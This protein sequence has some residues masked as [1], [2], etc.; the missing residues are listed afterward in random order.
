MLPENNEFDAVAVDES[1][2][3]AWPRVAAVAAMVAFSLPTFITGLE[4]S[5]GLTL[6]NTIWALV[7]GSV[8]VF[9]VGAA[10]GVIGAKSRMS[11][12]LLVRVAFG[13][14]GAGIVNIA[15]AISLLGWFGVNI[16]VF[17]EAVA[18][19][20]TDL[21]GIQFDPFVLAV[22]A[23]LCMTTTTLVG[24]RAINIGATVLVPVLAIVTLMLAWS[25]LS[26]SQLSQIWSVPK[27]ESSTVGAGISAVV[28]AIIIGAIIL[29][30]I[31]R[32]VRHWSGAVYTAFIGY[33][34]IQLAVL[35]AASLAGAVSGKTDILDVMLDVNLGLGAFIIVIAGSW[36][37]NSLNLYSAVL[38]IKATFSQLNDKWIT[39]VLGAIGVLAALMNILDSFINFLFYLS[40]IFVPVAGVLIIDALLIRPHAY[41]IDT[42]SDNRMIN[43]KGFLAWAAGAFVAVLGSENIIPSLSGTAALDSMLISSLVYIGLAWNERATTRESAK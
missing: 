16:N 21:W 1:K 10:T 4:V 3:T 42:L 31:T 34:V 8:I 2:L 43:Y 22:I 17:T 9:L 15:F 13:N 25:A 32:F 7:W 5:Q 26:S 14:V 6:A 24:F 27:V 19:L 20:G 28:G 36:V 29:P 11:S 37:L 12:Y 18:R 40:I 30:D 35:I 39:L 33:I 23:S 41:Q 38:S